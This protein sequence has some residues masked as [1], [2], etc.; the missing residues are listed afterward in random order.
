MW[1]VVDVEAPELQGSLDQAARLAAE[2]GIR[3][4]YANPCFELWLLLHQ[5]NHVGGYLRTKD[6]IAKMIGLGCCFTDG[7]DYN[8]EHFMG[9]PQR[10]AI[11][12][13]EQL[14]GKHGEGIHPRDKNPWTDI[15]ILV[16]DLLDQG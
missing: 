12:R 5:G 15:H 8:P 3:I 7:K 14:A 11:R 4:A 13:A 16:R 2:N 1:C 9:E 6:A 10:E